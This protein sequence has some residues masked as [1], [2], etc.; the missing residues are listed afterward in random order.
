MAIGRPGPWQRRILHNQKLVS[1]LETRLQLGG[2]QSRARSNWSSCEDLFSFHGSFEPMPGQPED[3]LM[4]AEDRL[5]RIRN[6][7]RYFFKTVG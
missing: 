7:L 1:N 6:V 5:L 3:G 4:F 2:F